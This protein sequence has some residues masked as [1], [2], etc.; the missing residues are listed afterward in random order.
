MD[1]VFNAWP[2]F[3]LKMSIFT[4]EF[5]KYVAPVYRPDK[6]EQKLVANS[7]HTYIKHEY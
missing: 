4:F 1:T 2:K 7:V 6:S 5:L 3:C